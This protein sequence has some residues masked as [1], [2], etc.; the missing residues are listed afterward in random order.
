L[1]SPNPS[2]PSS[3][4]LSISQQA[5]P[6]ALSALPAS[7]PWRV[8][9]FSSDPLRAELLHAA[10]PSSTSSL[11]M[12]AMPSRGASGARLPCGSS[13]LSLAVLLV[14]PS[15]SSPCPRCSLFFFCL[16]S[17]QTRRRAPLCAQFFLTRCCP[18]FG[19]FPAVFLR[20][21]S[22]S[23]AYPCVCVPELPAPVYFYGHWLI[24]HRSSWCSAASSCKSPASVAAV[25]ESDFSVV[26]ASSSPTVSH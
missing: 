16:P 12:A 10:A 4:L 20:T 14:V 19:N 13:P 7:S 23:A 3:F 21:R 22:S 25:S 2:Q 17:L 24:D 6:P 1:P 5:A 26:S 18:L 15:C 8:L 9:S 11:P